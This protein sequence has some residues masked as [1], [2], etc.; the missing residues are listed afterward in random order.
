M[1]AEQEQKRAWL[2]RAKTAEQYITA[3][4][5]Q[6]EK[7][8]RLIVFLSEFHD[9][10]VPEL[11]EKVANSIQ[12]QREQIEELISIREE[13]R[14]A[15]LEVQDDKLKTILTKHYLLYEPIDKVAENMHYDRRS[16]QRNHLKALDR[17]VMR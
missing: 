1:N 12:E 13:I 14:K 6:I 16:I 17:I 5:R 15:I 3:L 4:E 11:K 8:K 10:A 2:S 9:P 7:E